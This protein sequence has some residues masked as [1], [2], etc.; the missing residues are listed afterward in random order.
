VIN[1]A[2]GSSS[3][4]SIETTAQAGWCG[5]LLVRLQQARSSETTQL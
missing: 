1:K 2:H 3:S 5:W 4:S